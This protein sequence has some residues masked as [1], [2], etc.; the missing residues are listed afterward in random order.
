M[1][2]RFKRTKRP[3]LIPLPSRPAISNDGEET[4][5]GMVGDK[6]ASA[7]EE[8]MARALQKNNKQFMFRYVVGAPRGLPGWKEV[9]FIVLTGGVVY[10]LE[11]DTAFTHRN[12]EHKDRLHDAIILNDPEVK[13]L[14]VLW[15][16]VLHAD[17]DS[18]LA[19][20]RNADAY[21]RRIFGR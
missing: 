10:A 11:V 4:L 13:S 9:D 19:D 7:P 17:G 6:T 1:S 5:T 12:K 2:F 20:D 3:S 21:V 8:R 15:P 14:G 16:T 18:E